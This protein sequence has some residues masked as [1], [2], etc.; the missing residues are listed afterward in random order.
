MIMSR[1]DVETAAVSTSSVSI[2]ANHILLYSSF[3]IGNHFSNG[4]NNDIGHQP[5]NAHCCWLTSP[6]ET[7]GRFCSINRTHH[8]HCGT[9]WGHLVGLLCFLYNNF[10]LTSTESYLDHVFSNFVSYAVLHFDCKV[11]HLFAL[12]FR[13]LIYDL[14]NDFM[15]S[16]FLF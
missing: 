1:G 13:L 6:E 7:Q 16:V 11:M 4:V 12:H 5:D 15:I 2:S 3:L 8:Y 14:L 9:F 10:A